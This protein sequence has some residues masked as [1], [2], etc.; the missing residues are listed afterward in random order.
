MAEQ[1]I[2]QFICDECMED[3]DQSDRRDED[4]RAEE[5]RGEP[6]GQAAQEEVVTDAHEEM[7][8]EEGEDDSDRPRYNYDRASE[9]P[10]S[11]N[12]STSSG[13]S[14]V[15]LLASAPELEPPRPPSPSAYQDR[16]APGGITSMSLLAATAA[17]AARE[18]ESPPT[19]PRSRTTARVIPQSL[20]LPT[21]SS[22]VELASSNPSAGSRQ[23]RVWPTPTTEPHLF[24]DLHILNAH[25]LERLGNRPESIHYTARDVEDY[26][27]AYPYARRYARMITLPDPRALFDIIGL[28][29]RG[30]LRTLHNN[31]EEFALHPTMLSAVVNADWR[32]ESLLRHAAL[33]PVFPS[34]VPAGELNTALHNYTDER[35]SAAPMFM[36]VSP[37]VAFAS[38]L[39]WLPVQRGLLLTMEELARAALHN[40]SALLHAFEELQDQTEGLS[41]LPMLMYAFDTLLC[42][43]TACVVELLHH[44]VYGH[45]HAYVRMCEQRVR[46][47]VLKQPLFDQR[48]LFNMPTE[49]Y[50][51]TDATSN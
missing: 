27:L 16:A 5:T 47:E 46:H 41:R 1:F 50:R 7:S 33:T 38:R 19:D 32:L 21:V 24:A 51:G 26:E 22:V 35:M 29:R 12:G 8:S 36:P 11:P 49:A 10:A 25:D 39:R 13:T 9:P 37:G 14:S 34:V 31:R 18:T 48:R 6:E 30:F 40:H 28:R 3:S 43:Q 20:Q 42:Q 45:R 23:A 2:E 4:S 15:M 17:H 44:V